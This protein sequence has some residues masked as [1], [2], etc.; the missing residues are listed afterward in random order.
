MPPQKGCCPAPS[1]QAQASHLWRTR[2][3][4]GFA[5][6]TAATALTVCTGSP[7]W[8]APRVHCAPPPP[9]PHSRAARQ[10]SR[11]SPAACLQWM[12]KLTGA[13]RLQHAWWRNR[14]TDGDRPLASTVAST[15]W[16]VGGHCSQEVAA[17]PWQRAWFR[18]A[19]VQA[20]P[21]QVAMPTC[22]HCHTST[23]PKATATHRCSARPAQTR[24]DASPRAARRCRSPSGW[25]CRRS[26][27]GKVG[28]GHWCCR[29][30]STALVHAMPRVSKVG[31][32]TAESHHWCCP[33]ANEPPH[34]MRRPTQVNR[35]TT[36]LVQRQ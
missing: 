7:Q 5:S 35:R 4:C 1:Q 2:H 32:A 19:H 6:P 3:I 18:Y 9:M 10:A 29:P 27:N 12:R 13:L 11:W 22:R 28:S 23:Q 15:G 16:L 31:Q 20:L 14:H 17:M 21:H 26:S 30:C 33:A 36:P 25:R 24:G 8:P 34:L